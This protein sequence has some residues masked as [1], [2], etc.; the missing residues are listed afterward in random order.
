IADKPD[1][2]RVAA[3]AGLWLDEWDK[4]ALLRRFDNVSE[5][6]INTRE[7]ARA[8]RV[9]DTLGAASDALREAVREGA[10]LEDALSTVAH[11]FSDSDAEYAKSLDAA[12][13]LGH[14]LDAAD[15]SQRISTY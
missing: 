1:R 9:K 4:L 12:A 5:L 10:A 13:E 8:S 6:F 15:E 14:F 7:W 3:A 2:E 11:I